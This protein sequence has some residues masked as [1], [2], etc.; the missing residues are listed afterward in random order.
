MGR[1]RA[2]VHSGLLNLS[3][4]IK[5]V[6]LLICKKT[7]NFA[8]VMATAASRSEGKDVKLRWKLRQSE[9]QSS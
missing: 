9:K 6:A 8:R 7:L 2:Q 3:Y 5:R 1:V 4:H